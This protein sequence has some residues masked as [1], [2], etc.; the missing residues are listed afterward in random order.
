MTRRGVWS[1]RLALLAVVTISAVSSALYLGR[2]RELAARS[3]MPLPRRNQEK[4]STPGDS[5]AATGVWLR[6]VDRIEQARISAPRAAERAERGLLTKHWRRYRLPYAKPVGELGRFVQAV[7]LTQPLDSDD[8]S[9]TPSIKSRAVDSRGKRESHSSDQGE[10]DEREVRTFGLGEGSHDQRE[11]LVLAAPASLR[12]ELHVPA[13]A[14]LRTAPAVLGPNEVTFRI[15]FRSTSGALHSLGQ[16]TVRGTSKWYRD[17]SIDL[18]AAG[19]SELDGELEFSCESRANEPAIALWG[20]PVIVAPKASRL[21]YNVLFIIVDAMRSDAISASHDPVEDNARKQAEEPPLEA[22]FDELPEV[23]PELDKLAERGAIWYHSWSAAMWTR[24]STVSLL[25]GQRASHTGLDILALELLGDQRQRFYASRPPLLP[26]MMRAAGAS[27]A[28]IVNNMYLSGSVGVGIDFGFESVIDHR[29]QAQDTRQITRDAEQFLEQRQSERFFL[30]LNYAS[31]HAPYVPP[32]KDVRALRGAPNLPSDPTV[33]NYLAE[34]HKDDAAIG[35]VLSKL[36][37]LGLRENTLV[38]VTADHGETMSQAHDAVAVDVAQGVPSGRFTHLSTM[39]EEA[40]RVPILMALPG[41]IP[42]RQRLSSRVQAMDIVPTVLELEGL[43]IPAQVEGRSLVPELVGKPL[44]PRPVVIEGRGARS[45]IDGRYHLIVR[46]PI[47]RR[48]RQHREEIERAV[49]LYD[50]ERDPGE[51][52]EISTRYPQ[53]VQTLRA[54]LE[55]T[56][57]A[58]SSDPAAGIASQHWHFRFAAAGEARRLEVALPLSATDA[59]LTPVGID[60]RSIRVGSGEIRISTVTPPERAIGFDLEL[61]SSKRELSWSVKLDGQPWPTR[62][63]FV[64]PMGL[65]AAEFAGGYG[66]QSDLSCLDS[67]R[68]PHIAATEELGLFITRDPL[69]GAASSEDSEQAQ[70]EAQQAMQAWGYARKA[71]PGTK[72]H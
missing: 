40:A 69:T 7:G 51:R 1:L 21:P 9:R 61:P 8:A 5:G 14:T 52:R 43:P 37:A 44:V 49:E 45:I 18:Q 2:A 38:I 11:S 54:T 58:S 24:P 20:S 6:L 12:F 53:V 28:A 22:W 35:R 48:L 36:D 72:A 64:G 65:S 47:A 15:R 56:L 66:A 68:L 27:T 34:I 39:W 17:S 70:L 32:P 3:T 31:P 10:H 29:L 4:K 60:P 42:A 30:L 19:I 71:T 41:R 57:H 59:K 67:A 16:T 25:T 23:A 33:V 26:L 46:D 55:R 63:V 13:G 50:L 62:A